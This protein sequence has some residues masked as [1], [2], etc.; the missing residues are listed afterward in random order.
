ML[1]KIT[2]DQ[3]RAALKDMEEAEKAGL[4]YCEA[5]FNGS[6]V[7]DYWTS[8]EYSDLYEK[9]H[10]TDGR[11]NWGRGQKIRK[12]HIFKNGKLAP[13]KETLKNIKDY[14]AS[15][16]VESG[17]IDGYEYHIVDISDK[18][19]RLYDKTEAYNGY[20]IFPER[21]VL[22]EESKGILTYV[23]VHGGIT[24][25][26]QKSDG[27]V[28]GF[29]T[30]HNDSAKFPRGNKGWIK[31]QISKM[32]KGILK[33]VEVE[34]KYLSAKTE[35]AKAKYAQCVLDTDREK[36]NHSNLGINLNIL[37]GKL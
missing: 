36:E 14:P 31:K 26:E 8:A 13:T 23:P 29:D 15:A 10:P 24:Y 7:D 22:E 9:A 30:L 12:S 21:P 35:V 32:L 28:Y 27:M 17:Y 3:L 37:A 34:A 18:A 2:A 1:I 16:A 4:M 11:L 19:T 33:A 20:I 5:V 25:A 6:W